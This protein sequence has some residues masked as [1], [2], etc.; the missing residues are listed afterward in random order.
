MDPL[1]IDSSALTAL[2]LSFL[3][4]ILLPRPDRQHPVDVVAQPCHG[5][6]L[7][8]ELLNLLATDLST[9]CVDLPR[10]RDGLLPGS[11]WKQE[12]IKGKLLPW[13]WDLDEKMIERKERRRPVNWFGTPGTWIEWDWES[14]VRRLS[15]TQFYQDFTIHKVGEGLQLALKNRRRIFLIFDDLDKTK[16]SE[17]A[18][19]KEMDWA[20]DDCEWDVTPPLIR[21]DTGL[22]YQEKASA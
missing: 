7:P 21:Y 17:A 14:L 4:P 8:L 3:T 20:D 9:S 11:W 6:R 5:D 1:G 22:I 10:Q 16:M 12:L 18:R 2:V 13:L 15:Q 19:E